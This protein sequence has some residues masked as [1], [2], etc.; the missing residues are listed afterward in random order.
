MTRADWIALAAVIAIF[1]VACAAVGSFHPDRAFVTYRYAENV[2]AGDGFVYNAGDAPGEGYA[3]TLWLLAC[4]ALAACGGVLPAAAPVLSLLFGVVALVLLWVLLRA[5]TSFP[6]ALAGAG[7]A[8][9]SGPLAVAAMSGE[10]A[11]LVA[12]L[13][14]VLVALLA[15]PDSHRVTWGIAGVAGGLLAACG[16][17]LAI[18]FPVALA[19]R[20]LV[21][22][23]LRAP[24]RAEWM[25]ASGAFLAMLLAL[26]A[27]RAHTFGG[28]L[29]AS[30]FAS[31]RV[32]LP[33]LWL[34]Q[35]DDMA[36]WG[37]FYALWFVAG[38]AARARGDAVCWVALATAAA[39]GVASLATADA[40]PA[41]AGSAALVPLLIIPALALRTTSAPAASRVTAALVAAV[42]MLSLGG[43]ADAAIFARHLRATHDATLKPLGRWLSSWRPDGSLAG[44]A[45]G[46]VAYY[47]G[48][49]AAPLDRRAG[50][51]AAPD[52]VLVTS[53]GL[54]AADTDAFQSG[55]IAAIDGRYRM[56]AGI[57]TGWTRDRAYILYAR[58]DIPPLTDA[59]T[60]SFPNGLGSVTRLLR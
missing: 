3:S 48:W 2:A 45:I 24:A 40:L 13:G 49:R 55:V 31:G 26:H 17:A 14:L 6:V 52:L 10:G 42:L 11:T 51:T 58:A 44:V 18:V 1:L 30:P 5:R 32:S 37:W 27:W 23:E 15:R 12:T 43:A 59:E 4:A 21:K 25:T 46:A 20:V 28:V 60:G 41:L 8:A 34:A 7:F 56:L 47:S 57:R 39:T 53:D 54:F 33:S 22:R 35:P 16:H 50:L 19:A 29:A 9:A 38:V 36:P